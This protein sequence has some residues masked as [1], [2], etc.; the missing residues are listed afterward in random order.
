MAPTEQLSA[1][2]R[3]Q[4]LDW[5]LRIRQ[6]MQSQSEMLSGS[7]REFVRAAW[8]Q[9]EP[10]MA[11]VP[12]WHIDA[13]CDHLEAV[14]RGQIRN[15][16]INVPPGHAKSLL[17]SVLW[18][19]WV[20][21][22]KPGWRYI[23][24]SYNIDLSLRDALRCRTLIESS[25]YRGTFAPEW[26]FDQGQNAKG[27]YQNT[28]LGSR[29]STS[30]AAGN[31]GWRGDCIIVDD[32][33][34]AKDQFSD[35]KLEECLIWWDVVMSSRFNDMQRGNRVIIMQRLSDRDLSG[36]VLAKGGYEHL[37]LPTEFEPD[38]RCHTKIGWSDPRKKRGEL[39]FPEL[40]P[41]SVVEQAKRD[42]GQDGFAG[43]HQQRPTPAGGGMLKSHWWRYW[44]P[45]G[46]N[47]GPVP[48]K[49]PDGSIEH[50]NAIE[51]PVHFDEVL[52]SWDMAFKETATSDY[53]VGQVVAA[54]AADRFILDQD[55]ARM[56]LPKTLQ[57][58][59]SMSG[60]WPNAF[61]K[62]VEAKA[63]GPAVVQSLAHEVGG[64]IEIEPIGGKVSR[65]SGASPALESGN[66]YLPHPAIAPWVPDFIKEC[67]AFPRGVNDDQVDAWS[68]A[69][70]RLLHIQAA[71]PNDEELMFRIGRRGTGGWAA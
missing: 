36:H 39:L 21:L 5:Q 63:N 9:V 44:Q 16:L 20:W 4:I 58:V 19:A 27:F 57:A 41:D 49:M 32:C 38:N 23:G 59:R 11:F 2:A 68:Q 61:I 55:R 48:V 8:P 29:L 6:K 53:V 35:A 22:S 71:K 70:A 60:R 1:E 31:T 17:V 66:W 62:L 12:N 51:I 54:T 15:L 24:S 64:F 34:S 69:A 30:V 65:A 67:A 56:D 46:A 40:F 43:Q 33:L 14:T 28:A 37:M 3:F 26:T 47:L 10:S 7:L 13:I 50:R 42:M 52:Q 25:W 18:P 45:R